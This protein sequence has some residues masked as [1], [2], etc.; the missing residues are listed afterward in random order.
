MIFGID[1]EEESV[2]LRAFTFEEKIK[3]AFSTGYLGF[4]EKLVKCV[5]AFV[6]EM[7]C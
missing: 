4:G 6:E 5:C 7:N 2:C 3:M 1:K